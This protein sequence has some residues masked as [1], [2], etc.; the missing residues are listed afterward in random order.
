MLVY[1]IEDVLFQFCVL[2]RIEC[3][4]NKDV[5]TLKLNGYSQTND[6]SNLIKVIDCEMLINSDLADVF[7][8]DLINNLLRH[9]LME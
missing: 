5:K 1:K 7:T 4:L 3:W 8:F 9:L 2:V 6:E